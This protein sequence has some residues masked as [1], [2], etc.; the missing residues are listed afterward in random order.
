MRDD[1]V[2]ASRGIVKAGA[3]VEPHLIL[4]WEGIQ[5]IDVHVHIAP[6]ERCQARI[7]GRP[8]SYF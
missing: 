4:W 8:N 3:V 6:D 7:S 1:L 5:P 2:L